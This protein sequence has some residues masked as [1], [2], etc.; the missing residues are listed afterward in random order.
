MSISLFMCAVT[1][2]SHASAQH[3]YFPLKAGATWTYTYPEVVDP[4]N[5][6]S[7]VRHVIDASDVDGTYRVQEDQRI[8]TLPRTRVVHT[9]EIRNGN[10]LLMSDE[11][12]GDFPG[13]LGT[14]G[15]HLKVPAPIV[16]GANLEKGMHWKGGPTKGMRECTVL[17]F[18]D[19]R[20]AAGTFEKVAKI[21]VK[22]SY[23]SSDTNRE[24]FGPTT[25][26][27]YAP[28][29]GLVKIDVLLETGKFGTYLE[30]TEYSVPEEPR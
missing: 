14:Q 2:P 25:H 24:K 12:S 9:Y 16:L 10:V 30:L 17:D 23:I 21:L 11:L 26:E 29:V 4:S 22:I 15:R 28:N 27:Y 19:L 7:N 20:V 18:V 3:P 1:Q 5:S 13:S 6:S 8:A